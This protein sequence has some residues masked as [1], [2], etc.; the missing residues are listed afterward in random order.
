M[1]TWVINGNSSQNYNMY[2]LSF[3]WISF[4]ESFQFLLYQLQL[5]EDIWQ[6]QNKLRQLVQ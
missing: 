3:L 4:I 6:I 1:T 2:T 5:W